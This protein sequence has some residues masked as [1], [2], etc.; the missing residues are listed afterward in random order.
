[1]PKKIHG[2]RTSRLVDFS[3][4]DHSA[5]IKPIKWITIFCYLAKLQIT[6]TSFSNYVLNF[7]K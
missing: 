3:A 7:L 6:E 1:M 4:R 2:V 5:R